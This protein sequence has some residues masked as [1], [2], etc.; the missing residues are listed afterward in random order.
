MGVIREK[1]QSG[2]I[3]PIGT[4][5]LNTGGVEKYNSIAKAANSMF[6]IALNEMS[7]SSAKEGADRAAA[8]SSSEITT[9]NPITGKPEALDDFNADMFLGRTA[10][11]AYQRVITDRFNTEISNDIKVKANE[12]TTKYQDNPNNIQIVSEALGEYVKNLAFGSERN[13]KP[14]LFTNF[15]EDNGKVEIANAKLTLTKT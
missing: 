14:T 6:E 10:G 12:L 15:I 5:N 11:E 7:R 3:G 1:R 4:V 13:G 8:V 2:S 9:V